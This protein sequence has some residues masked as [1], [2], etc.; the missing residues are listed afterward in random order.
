MV[1][2]QVSPIFRDYFPMTESY[3]PDTLI[4][5]EKEIAAIDRALYLVGVGRPSNVGIFGGP[6]CGKTVAVRYLT[7]RLPGHR[8]QT[9]HVNCSNHRTSARAIVAALQLMG[10]PTYKGMGISEAVP[11]L[12][13]AMAIAP[14]I[15]Y[16][17]IFDEIH[18]VAD[19]DQILYTFS[20]LHEFDQGKLESINKATF[21]ITTDVQFLN[22]MTTLN[23]AAVSTFAPQ[24][25]VFP[26]YDAMALRA[27]LEDRASRSFSENA[28]PLE[29]IAL[30]AAV[31][32]QEVG[33]ARAAIQ[34]LRSAGERADSEGRSAIS[35]EDVRYAHSQMEAFACLD[36]IK[37]LPTHSRVFLMAVRDLAKGGVPVESGKVYLKYL[38]LCRDRGLN[39]LT[40]RRAQFLATDLAGYNLIS[41]HDTY[42]FEGRRGRTRVLML[43]HD[44][45]KALA[46]QAYI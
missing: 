42:G 8:Y 15:A 33:S 4:G 2:S 28:C 37:A 18:H 22:R 7:K 24:Q 20:R 30:V 39:A 17:F 46:N 35:D 9:I 45:E 12:I 23:A 44:V 1:D 25:I 27:I 6:G 41:G 13:N 14:G 11:A 3:I 40:Q 34:M 19:A 43:T 32:A 10:Q 36:T 21:F 5:R 26:H 31:S 16:L 38:E 29:T